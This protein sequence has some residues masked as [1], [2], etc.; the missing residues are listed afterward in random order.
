VIIWFIS[1]NSWA[2]WQKESEEYLSWFELKWERV[3]S[4]IINNLALQ[5]EYIIR[6]IQGKTNLLLWL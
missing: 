1:K 3:T 6:S 4:E 2:L 5:S